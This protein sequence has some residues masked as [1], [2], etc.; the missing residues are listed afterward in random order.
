MRGD[1]RRKNDNRGMSLIE[2][3]ITVAIM[4]TIL[5]AAGFGISLISGRPAEACV[6]KLVSSIQH[7]RTATMGK[8]KTGI[9]I[10]MDAE[11][12]IVAEE[13]SERLIDNDGT[14]SVEEKERIVGDKG[15]TVSC[16]MTDG[17]SVQITGGNTLEL[18][19]DRSSGALKTTKINGV[20]SQPCVG[21]TVSMRD[22][23]KY[24][25]ITPVTGKL[26]ITDTPSV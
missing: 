16:S 14:I 3:I 26:A 2:I 10:Y 20:V 25:V 9:S 12:R 21:V 7:A 13:T 17:S 22:K 8:N 18:E 15:V 1:L 4:S 6:Q 19:F 23:T 11:G 24:I 5:G